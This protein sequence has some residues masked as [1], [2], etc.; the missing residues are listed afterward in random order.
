MKPQ[1]DHIGNGQLLSL[2]VTSQSFLL[3]NERKPLENGLLLLAVY[4]GVALILLL[5]L[6]L[7]RRAVWRHSV[8]DCPRLRGALWMIAMAYFIASTHLL[9]D[10]ASVIFQGRF[11]PFLMMLILIAVIAGTT[12]MGIEALCR[13]AFVL[14]FFFLAALLLLGVGSA[15]QC[16]LLNLTLPESSADTFLRSFGT[17]LPAVG[18]ELLIFLLIQPLTIRPDA[19]GQGGWVLVSFGISA[20]LLVLAALCMGNY[21]AITAYPIYALSRAA[22]ICSTA[23]MTPVYWFM[24]LCAATVRLTALLS[25]AVHLR[26]TSRNRFPWPETAL[27]VAVVLLLLYS[28]AK[29]LLLQQIAGIALLATL[30]L[31]CFWAWKEKAK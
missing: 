24:L 19:P 20:V 14:M 28:D 11:S 3:L 17:R 22:D 16:T 26:G 13:S 25:V 9:L 27:A 8:Y 10:E 15:D 18:A 1:S 5:A 29:V 6:H 2:L 30:I 31:R 12:A 4:A 23:G 21:G 7:F